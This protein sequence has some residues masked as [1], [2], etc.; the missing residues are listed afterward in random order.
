MT[1]KIHFIDE[2][3]KS[4][5]DHISGN[6]SVVHFILTQEDLRRRYKSS[7]NFIDRA[8]C[9]NGSA[10]TNKSGLWKDVTCP[11]CLKYKDNPELI[12]RNIPQY[13]AVFHAT[14]KR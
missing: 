13:N 1:I 3:I 6:K 10:H 8:L 5:Q 4:Q 9:G 14:F 11:A 7:G 2:M 12:E